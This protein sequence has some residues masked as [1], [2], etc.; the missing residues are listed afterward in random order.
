MSLSTVRDPALYERLTPENAALLLI[1]HQTGL[2]LGVGTL[3]PTKLRNNALAFAELGKVFNLPTVVT[4]SA[5]DGPN[6]PLM[7]EIAAMYGKDNVINRHMVSAW[8]DP[9][10]VAA[11]EKTG[12]RKLIMGA[13][14]TDVCLLFPALAA[15]AAGYDVYAV[16]D[17]SGTWDALSEQA[18]LLRLSQAGVKVCNWVSVAAEL[19]RDWSG[20]YAKGVGQLLTDR[21]GP[22]HFLAN[23]FAAK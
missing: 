13:I 5:S 2:M 3:E 16:A 17:A 11:V 19:L 9:K 23:N 1:D 12:R 22:Y 10:F 18:S 21:L 6:G 8:D 20:P 14:T 7:A 15:T 4:T